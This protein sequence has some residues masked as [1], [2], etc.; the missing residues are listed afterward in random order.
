MTLISLH[1]SLL[2]HPFSSSFAPVYKFAPELDSLAFKIANQ[3]RDIWHAGDAPWRKRT[4]YLNYA[5]GDETAEQLYGYESWR[6]ERLRALK[7][8]YDPNG[9]LVFFNPFN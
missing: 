6:L 2:T 3:A 4:A 9:K 1:K 5:A 8:K 7:K